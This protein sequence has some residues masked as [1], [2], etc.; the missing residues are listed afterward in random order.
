MGRELASTMLRGDTGRWAFLNRM[1]QP[2]LSWGEG[3]GEGERSIP[4]MTGRGGW[5]PCDEHYLT[6]FVRDFTTL[7][8]RKGVYRR[9]SHNVNS[10]HGAVKCNASTFDSTSPPGVFSDSL[11]LT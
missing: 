11:Y 10:S 3:R 8:A 2:S 1:A 5:Y 6:L 7:L 4:L 9:G